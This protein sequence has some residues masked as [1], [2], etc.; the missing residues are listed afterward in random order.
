M[1]THALIAEDVKE[2]QQLSTKNRRMITIKRISN[3]LLQP[4][5]GIIKAGKLLKQSDSLNKGI[6]QYWPAPKNG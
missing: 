5:I 4:D 2:V 3:Q 6:E 1:I